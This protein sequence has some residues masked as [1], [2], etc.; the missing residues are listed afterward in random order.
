MQLKRQKGIRKA[1]WRATSLSVLLKGT[2]I[3][4]SS[5]HVKVNKKKSSGLVPE[6][7]KITC[8]TKTRVGVLTL[9]RDTTAR[10]KR[11]NLLLAGGRVTTTGDPWQNPNQTQF[12][13]N[14]SLSSRGKVKAVIQNQVTDANFLADK[15][16]KSCV[17]WG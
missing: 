10:R 11:T 5:K 6:V 15:V 7:T 4:T 16:S 17:Y 12:A 9:K 14:P 13:L 8:S 1:R 2:S 3:S